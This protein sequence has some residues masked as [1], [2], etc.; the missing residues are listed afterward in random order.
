MELKRGTDK[1]SIILLLRFNRTFMELK[2]S[3]ELLSA[4]MRLR[5]NRTFMELK[6][7]STH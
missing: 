6:P 3:R 7:L 4:N 1:M 5:F 2:L